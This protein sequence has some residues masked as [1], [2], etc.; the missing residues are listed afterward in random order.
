MTLKTEKKEEWD[1]IWVR[2]LG[3]QGN[4]RRTPQ[5]PQNRRKL[6]PQCNGEKSTEKQKE[7]DIS[8]YG[9]LKIRNV[10][11]VEEPINSRP[12][13]RKSKPTPQ[14]LTNPYVPLSEIV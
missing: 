5:L 11:V 8:H 1:I 10:A 2:V 6:V 13:K 14:H 9:R 4:R 3:G 12:H 7:I